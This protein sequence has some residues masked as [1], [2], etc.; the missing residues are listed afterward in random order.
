MS[1][2][3]IFTTAELEQQA[4]ILYRAAMDLYDKLPG[5]TWTAQYAVMHEA[6]KDLLALM[7]ACH[8]ELARR[9]ATAAAS[10]APLFPLAST[11]VHTDDP[12]EQFALVAE[13]EA[14]TRADYPDR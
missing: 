6:A 9:F 2:L 8:L 4:D 14:A 5:A 13:F 12:D 7:R 11:S 3:D 1:D 10:A